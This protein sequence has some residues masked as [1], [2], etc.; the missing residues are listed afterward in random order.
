MPS[1]L[2]EMEC[3]LSKSTPPGVHVGQDLCSVGAGGCYHKIMGEDYWPENLKRGKGEVSLLKS[4]REKVFIYIYK[5]R[6][7]PAAPTLQSDLVLVLHY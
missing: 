2:S 5:I 6:Y 7:Q 3:A 4:Y 1:L